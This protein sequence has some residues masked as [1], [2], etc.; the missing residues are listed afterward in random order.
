VW[1]RYTDRVPVGLTCSDHAN[2]DRISLGHLS[3]TG[4]IPGSIAMLTSLKTLD[5]SYNSI[6][7]VIPAVMAT[8]TS[9]ETVDLRSNNI[10]GTIPREFSTNVNSSL[11]NLYLDYNTIQDAVPTFLLGLRSLVVFSAVAN[12]LFGE[13]PTSFCS[14]SSNESTV[15]FNFEDNGRISCAQ[16]CYG[17]G[18]PDGQMPSNVH[19]TVGYCDPTSSPTVSPAM[20]PTPGPSAYTLSSSSSAL[21]VG[22][23]IGLSVGVPVGMIIF[24]ALACLLPGIRHKRMRYV[25]LPMH[26]AIDENNFKTLTNPSF[27]STHISSLR[28]RDLDGRTVVALLLHK[29]EW[30]KTQNGAEPTFKDSDA[31]IETALY[32]LV[33]HSLHFDPVTGDRIPEN[34]DLFAWAT[35][36][37]SD[38]N[39]AY[40][41]TLRFLTELDNFI[42]LLS[43]SVDNLGRKSVDIAS[44]RNRSAIH[45]SS[46]LFNQFELKLGPPEHKSATSIVK[47]AVF[48]KDIDLEANDGTKGFTALPSTANVALKFMKF[49]SQYLTEIN[50]RATAQFSEEYVMQIIE[51]YDGDGTDDRNKGFRKSAFKRG[52]ESYPYCV[53]MDVADSSLQRAIFQQHIAGHEWEIIR[54]YIK[55]LC[56]CL[57]HIFSLNIVHGDLKPMNIVLMNNSVRLI[58]FDAASKFERSGAYPSTGEYAGSK[59]SSAYL[60]PEMF[61]ENSVGTIMVRSYEKDPDTGQPLGA[62]RSA[63]GELYHL[64]V[65]YALRKSDPSQDMWAL[66]AILY[67]LCTGEQLFQA[68]IEDNVSGSAMSE[69]YLWTDDTKEQ[70]LSKVSDRYARNLISLLLQ[71]NPTKRL[72][73]EQVVGHPFVM[74]GVQPRRLQGEPPKYDI[75]LS[76]RVDSDSEHV[77]R[78]Y[79]ELLRLELTVWLDK[80]CLQ[81]G[82]PWEEGFCEGLAS[83]SCFVC[84][85]SR[86][87]INHPD[88][89]W[90]NFSKLESGSRCDNVLLEWRL[91][92]E[93]KEREMIEGIFPIFIGDA[94]MTSEG[95]LQ[96]SNYFSSG[97]HPKILPDV[98]ISSVESK[99]REHLSHQ[100]LGCPLDE[101][102]SVKDVVETIT[103]SQGGFLSGE[104]DQVLTDICR[105]ISLM[106]RNICSVEAEEEVTEFTV[107]DIADSFELSTEA[108]NNYLLTEN[109]KLSQRILDLQVQLEKLKHSVET[110][111]AASVAVSNDV[112]MPLDSPVKKE[113]SQAAGTAEASHMSS[114]ARLIQLFKPGSTSR[115]YNAPVLPEVIDIAGEDWIS[116]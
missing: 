89:P 104:P 103:S 29:M 88:K 81:P 7:G 32:N 73:P 45:K 90:Q 11:Q 10:V 14:L 94:S 112:V 72:T 48:H 4:I 28:R 15:I 53:V 44:P 47:F 83:S 23:T 98:S 99:L 35:L 37:Q 31:E 96:Y 64:G 21:S 12:D 87:A 100:G 76:Y 95:Q 25:G 79:Q 39:V 78:I 20:V 58:D 77:D 50:T 54:L 70:K 59:Y 80:V 5:L 91:A 110:A 17:Y 66:G 34:E 38:H 56:A 42:D 36:I 109:S 41:V 18:T 116:N 82:Q 62:S 8:L 101:R 114:F 61:F 84:L 65:G 6:S 30:S 52:F 102:R 113:L 69:V 19:M 33:Y 86:N 105:K 24:C 40:K 57:T 93:L 68:S 60:P 115:R 71:K 92:L 111:K 51:S 85:I 3:L 46:M 27:L 26:K 2:V 75:F 13:I 9:L 49:R 74:G 1:S 63:N 16:R 106:R 43:N 97:C 55:S 67:L 107:A 108:R 22:E